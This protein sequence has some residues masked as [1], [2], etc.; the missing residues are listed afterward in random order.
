MDVLVI[1]MELRYCV[2][3]RPWGERV[4]VVLGK[5]VLV[6]LATTLPEVAQSCAV[7]YRHCY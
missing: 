5:G 1:S 3:V 7:G 6:V 4:R 2:L